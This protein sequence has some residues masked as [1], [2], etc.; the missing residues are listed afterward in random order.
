M[1]VLLQ[2]RQLTR[3]LEQQ[4]GLLATLLLPLPAELQQEEQIEA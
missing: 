1:V 4:V 3:R 2:T